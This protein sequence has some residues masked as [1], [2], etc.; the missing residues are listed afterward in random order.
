MPR[1][2]TRKSFHWLTTALKERREDKKISQVDI[3]I[4]FNVTQ[5]T[6]SN[7]ANHPEKFLT[8]DKNWV[9]RFIER[10]GF[11][12]S[13]A[14]VMA[15]RLFADDFKE[16]FGNKDNFEKHVIRDLEE[17]VI[18]VYGSASAGSGNSE[19]IEGFLRIPKISL[20]GRD[21][22]NIYALLVNQDCLVSHDVRFSVKNVAHGDYVAVDEMQVP[23]SS[24]IVVYWDNRQEKLILKLFKEKD[25]SIILYDGKGNM[26]PSAQFEDDLI[27]KGVAFWRGGSTNL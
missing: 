26:I 22:K 13:E 6:I 16:I 17:D 21:K 27:F 8:Q 10:H 19:D 4:D 7:Y 12:K 24:S 14:Q 1:T 20:R 2:P 15:Q 25:S 18:P 3:S 11:S 23:V 5:G 9:I